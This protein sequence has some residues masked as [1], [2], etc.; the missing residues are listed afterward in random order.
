M[1]EFVDFLVITAGNNFFY[2]FSVEFF[3]VTFPGFVEDAHAIDDDI[4]AYKQL[5]ETL[6]FGNVG[7]K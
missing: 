1:N 7:L 3:K 4:N 6:K 2:E 5:I